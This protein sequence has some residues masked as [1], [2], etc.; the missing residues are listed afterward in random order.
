VV[1]NTDAVTLFGAG[2]TAITEGNL[3]FTAQNQGTF[4]MNTRL[5]RARSR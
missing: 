1:D 4:P 3:D 2:A 5:G